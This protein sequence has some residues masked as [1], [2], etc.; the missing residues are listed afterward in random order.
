M[1]TTA[2]IAGTEWLLRQNPGVS[3][4]RQPHQGDMRA[5]ICGWMQDLSVSMHWHIY[6]ERHES[7]ENGSKTAPGHFYH[8]FCGRWAP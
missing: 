3:S 1:I 8:A 5:G 6:H 7:T 2:C 4:L